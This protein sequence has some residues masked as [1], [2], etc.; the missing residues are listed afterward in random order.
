[1]YRKMIV[2]NRVHLTFEKQSMQKLYNTIHENLSVLSS[3][4]Y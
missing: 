4:Y 1:M 2:W 3:D